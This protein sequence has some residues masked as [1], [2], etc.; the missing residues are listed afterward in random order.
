MTRLKAFFRRVHDKPRIAD[1]SFLSGII[2]TNRTVL[3]YCDASRKYGPAKTL[4]D[5]W[6]RRSRNS[7]FARIMVNLATESAEHSTVIDDQNYLKRFCINLI[8]TLPRGSS[9]STPGVRT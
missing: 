1:R 2:F 9:S 5:R 8:H 6:K 7:V 3:Q 4:Y